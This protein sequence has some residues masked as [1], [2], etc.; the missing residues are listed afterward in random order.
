[1]QIQDP[2]HRHAER[3]A[4]VLPLPVSSSATPTVTSSARRLSSRR[5]VSTPVPSST[6]ARRPSLRS[7]T[8]SLS[9]SCLRVLSSATSRRRRVTVERSLVPLA[10]TRLSSATPPMRTRL[11]FVFL[12]ARRRPSPA[13]TV[14][15]SVSLRAVAVSTSPYSRPAGH[16][17]SSRPSATSASSPYHTI[18]KGR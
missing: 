7:A 8:S 1:M 4:V 16:T 17:T 14:L 15:P 11:A 18:A 9:R 5:R 10:T 3:R 12:P 6:A 13:A 2:V